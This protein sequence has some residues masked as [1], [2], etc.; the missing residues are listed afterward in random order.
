MGDQNTR[1]GYIVFVET[2]L[3]YMCVY[4]YLPWYTNVRFI[5]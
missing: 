3:Y 1:D 4:G 5:S 2:L